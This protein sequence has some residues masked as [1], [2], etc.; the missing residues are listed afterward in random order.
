MAICLVDGLFQKVCIGVVHFDA[1][2]R[3]VINPNVRNVI[4][5]ID[6]KSFALVFET[7]H[8]IFVHAVL[9]TDFFQG[10]HQQVARFLIFFVEGG[11]DGFV[12]LFVIRLC[13]LVTSDGVTDLTYNIKADNEK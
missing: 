8:I 10:F 11:I 5:R 1:C 3:I 6:L 7:N 2:P 12:R 4:I 9:A 13:S